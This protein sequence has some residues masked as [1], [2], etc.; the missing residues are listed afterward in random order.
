M[1]PHTALIALAVGLC[2][3]A[4]P[5]LT[6]EFPASVTVTADEANG[7][8]EVR[9]P[10]AAFDGAEVA[11]RLAD[12][13]VTR[14]AWR[15]A[16]G[17][18][19]TLQI[20]APLRD[21]L[22]ADGFEVLFECRD[23]VCGGYDFRFA[24]DI[25]GE[26][27]MHVDLGDFRY[28]LAESPVGVTVALIV[29]RSPSHGFVQLTRVGGD[30]PLRDVVVT[31]S[32]SEAFSAPLNAGPLLA[33]LSET[34]RAPLDDLLFQSGSAELERSDFPSLA[35]LA[36]YLGTNP[37]ITVTLVGHTDATGGLEGNIALSRRRAEAVRATLIRDHGV[38]SAQVG[39]QGV[40]YLAP[41]ASNATD[42]GRSANRRVEVVLDR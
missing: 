22:L 20:L 18:I 30:L 33:G 26:P 4:A 9:L 3:L 19:T 15:L 24:A 8:D 29:S 35:A 21:Q 16:A 25:L 32:K 14:Q 28:L 2:P 12:G 13:Q 34:G 40:G 31:S 23:R 38:R 17:R 6:L 11:M 27:A 39:A 41:R 37:D 1:K 42:D 36:G 10:M 5:A 7:A